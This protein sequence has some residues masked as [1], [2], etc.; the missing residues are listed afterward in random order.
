[1]AKPG[2][3][4]PNCRVDGPD[5]GGHARIIRGANGP[6]QVVLCHGSAS[7]GTSIVRGPP[8]VT[9]N[10][11]HVTPFTQSGINTSAIGQRPA[12]F[13]A[14]ETS[15][16]EERANG[17]S[18]GKTQT[19]SSP[20]T[21]RAAGAARRLPEGLHHLAGDQPRNRPRA[22]RAGPRK[23][24]RLRAVHAACPEPFGLRPE[25]E[26]A[27]TS[28]W[29]I[30]RSSSAAS[31]STPPVPADHARRSRP[32]ARDGAARHQGHVRLGHRRA[33]GRLPARVRLPD[34]ARPPR[35]PS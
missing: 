20:S 10:T 14:R 25:G 11:P 22:R 29:R 28:N 8:L 18:E 17:S 35:A 6:N 1:M 21:A 33:A 9:G 16:F 15:T 24:Q 30:P 4:A 3:S 7:W 26:E 13:L 32:V 34:H 31:P 27:A 12:S 5:D 23:L 2:P 19:L